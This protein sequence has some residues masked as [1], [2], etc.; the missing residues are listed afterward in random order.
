MWGWAV[1]GW[2][3]FSGAKKSSELVLTLRREGDQIKRRF[4]AQFI[5]TDF[6]DKLAQLANKPV[7]L[8]ALGRYRLARIA[9]KLLGDSNFSLLTKWQ[10][11][12]W[13]LDII[14]SRIL[15]SNE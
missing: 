5:D 6:G 4:E 12:P 9:Q 11:V 7:L 8:E 13:Y 2:N 10:D 15:E 14:G 3:R 1:G